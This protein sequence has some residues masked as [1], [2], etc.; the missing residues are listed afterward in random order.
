MRQA[1]E[2]ADRVYVLQRGRIVMS[3]TSDQIARDIDVV[4]RAYLTGV[5][6]EPAD[7]VV[8]G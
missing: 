7:V 6:D 3:G 1:L 8:E 2:I 4:E 5:V